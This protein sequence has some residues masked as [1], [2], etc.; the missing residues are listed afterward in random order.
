M[1]TIFAETLKSLRTQKGLTQLEMA[2]QTAPKILLRL[3]CLLFAD[4][5][6]TDHPFFRSII[7]IAGFLHSFQRIFNDR[8]HTVRSARPVFT[9]A[10]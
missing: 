5:S 3:P 10:A 7:H 6:H 1:S 8:Y 4:D 9:P 2:E